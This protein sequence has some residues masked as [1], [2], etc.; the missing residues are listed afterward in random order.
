MIETV[1]KGLRNLY[2]FSTNFLRVT[3][4]TAKLNS[5]DHIFNFV[6]L[7]CHKHCILDQNTVQQVDKLFLKTFL[8]VTRPLKCVAQFKFIVSHKRSMS[9]V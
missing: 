1:S 5:F 6:S 9:A 8:R 3:R 2:T 4:L 7:L